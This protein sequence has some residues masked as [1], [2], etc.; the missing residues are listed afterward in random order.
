MSRK[1]N[2][3]SRLWVAWIKTCASS[4]AEPCEASIAISSEEAD[5][6][7]FERFAARASSGCYT[8]AASPAVGINGEQEMITGD[9]PSV[10][11]EDPFPQAND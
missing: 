10:R 5:F 1:G 11:R 6:D 3:D 9:E 7:A 2:G 8:F 4:A